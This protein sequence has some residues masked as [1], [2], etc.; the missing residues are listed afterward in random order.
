MNHREI[1]ERLERLGEE[2]NIEGMKRFGIVSK[3]ARILGV[4]KPE[5]RK[6]AKE[7]GKNKKLAL[8]LWQEPIHEARIL[9]T[10]VFPKEKFKKEVLYEW[11]KDIDNWDLCDQLVLNLLWRLEDAFEIAKEFAKK[12]AEFEKRVG[13]ALMAVLFRKRKTESKE[14]FSELAR[15]IEE[16]LKDKRKYVKKAAAWAKREAEKFII[17]GAQ[18]M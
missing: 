11:I 13:Y 2:K 12:E 18:K 14:C 5:I 9:A 10:I 4:P 15:L 1:I 8:K 3:K 7:I 17:L 16:G 6:L